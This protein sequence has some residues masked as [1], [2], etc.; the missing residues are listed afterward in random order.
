MSEC[1]YQLSTIYQ[2]V[3]FTYFTPSPF[4]VFLQPEFTQL[5][6]NEKI[7]F[8]HFLCFSCCVFWP[9]FGC[10]SHPK[11]GQNRGG[12]DY[13]MPS[14]VTLMLFRSGQ[15]LLDVRKQYAL[16]S[17]DRNSSKLV[18]TFMSQQFGS[19]WTFSNILTFG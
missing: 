10:F 4:G 9:A 2:G 8:M 6:S 16:H 11:V 12:R 19:E 5:D 7:T 15:G 13:W 3:H 1:K 17:F 18:L 14:K